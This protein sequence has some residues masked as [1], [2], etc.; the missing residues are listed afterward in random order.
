MNYE[1]KLPKPTFVRA[2]DYKRVEGSNFII[3]RNEFGGATYVTG[4]AHRK[5]STNLEVEHALRMGKL[6]AMWAGKH[7]LYSKVMPDEGRE[8]LKV[9]WEAEIKR[10][11]PQPEVSD[12]DKSA[13]DI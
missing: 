1:R 5:L 13:F 12:Y 7:F 8:I 2:N 4:K 9:I 3:K 10:G 6:V 11:I